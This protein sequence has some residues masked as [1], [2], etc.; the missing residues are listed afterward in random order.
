ME[1]NQFEMALKK[2]VTEVVGK[3]ESEVNTCNI[4]QFDLLLVIKSPVF[5]RVY[6]D[7]SLFMSSFEIVNI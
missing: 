7:K 2:R 4:P 5:K 3:I 1:F 6:K